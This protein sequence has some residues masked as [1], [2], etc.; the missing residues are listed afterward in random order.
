MCFNEQMPVKLEKLVNKTF[1][2]SYYPNSQN[3][4][5]ICAFH[6]SKEK[7]TQVT[8]EVLLFQHFR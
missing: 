1:K 4:G 7:E 5:L 8:C 3:E 6:K 2:T